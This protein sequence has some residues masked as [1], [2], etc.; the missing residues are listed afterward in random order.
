MTPEEELSQLE[1][2][3]INLNASL[4]SNHSDIGDWKL[5][6]NA[7]ANLLG[8]PLPYDTQ[9][10]HEKRQ[11]VRDRINVVNERIKELEKEIQPN[12]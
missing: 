1:C 8:L 5:I 10:L 7:E 9:D 11:A 4:N 2:E 12:S 3:L 6:K